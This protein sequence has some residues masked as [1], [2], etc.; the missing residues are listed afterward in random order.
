MTCP[1]YKGNS[2]CAAC[3]HGLYVPPKE[4]EILLCA[5]GHYS[6]CDEYR[7]FTLHMLA[8]EANG[9]PEA[10]GNSACKGRGKRK[11]PREKKVRDRAKWSEIPI[12]PSNVRRQG[13]KHSDPRE[14]EL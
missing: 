10:K 7:R 12:V 13:T 3:E 8:S 5:R 11:G 1:Y 14:E 4:K 9:T 6:I 2:M